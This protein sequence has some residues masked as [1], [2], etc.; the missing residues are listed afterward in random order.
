MDVESKKVGILSNPRFLLVLVSGQALILLLSK[1]LYWPVP[2]FELA[3]VPP[4]DFGTL[5]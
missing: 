3:V 5:K 4:A 1:K 2:V